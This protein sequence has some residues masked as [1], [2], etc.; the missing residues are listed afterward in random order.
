MYPFIEMLK[1]SPENLETIQIWADSLEEIGD[2][3]AEWLRWWAIQ[4]PQEIKNLKIMSWSDSS[5][6]PSNQIIGV[7]V[8]DMAFRYMPLPQG[9][10][11]ID[12]V[13]KIEKF[14]S[15]FMILKS[16]KLVSEEDLKDSKDNLTLYYYKNR[17]ESPLRYLALSMLQS[18]GRYYGAYYG[19]YM[20][21]IIDC[22]KNSAYCQASELGSSGNVAWVASNNWIVSLLQVAE[23]T[24]PNRR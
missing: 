6:K 4:L 16:L 24:A 18:I 21:S 9:G 5:F 7:S 14:A 11:I 13:S 22:M 15:S 19:G 20:K 10:H 23:K 1:D 12:Q 17:N 8:L 2:P 3:R